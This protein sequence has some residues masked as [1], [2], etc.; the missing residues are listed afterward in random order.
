MGLKTNQSLKNLVRRRGLE[1]LHP[2]KAPGP[3]PG[4]STNFATLADAKLN[5]DFAKQ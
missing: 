1:P 4:A 5:Q 3:K 2:F